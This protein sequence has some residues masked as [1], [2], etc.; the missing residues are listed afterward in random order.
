MTGTPAKTL[1]VDMS[2]GEEPKYARC[3]PWQY[4]W[5][6]VMACEPDHCLTVKELYNAGFR[7]ADLRLEE[8]GHA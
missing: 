4:R 8:W 6:I 3:S 5:L 7:G 1:I 2:Q